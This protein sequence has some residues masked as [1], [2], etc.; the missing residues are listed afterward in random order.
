MY[1]FFLLF[2]FFFFFNDTATTE[3]YTLSL[4]DALPIFPRIARAY[5]EPFGNSSALPTYFCAKLAKEDGQD[6]LLA[7]D[8]G[9]ELFGGNERYAK[10]LLFASYEQ[11]PS[12]IRHRF[13][14][15]ILSIP[16][17]RRLPVF[18]KAYSYVTQAKT[19]LPDRLEAYNFLHRH[20]AS[21]VFSDELVTS[22]N[23]DQPLELLRTL[24]D[25]PHDASP[26]NR[27]LFLD[28]ERTLHDNDL[29]KVN[30]MCQ[31]AGIDVA[32]PMLDD[33]VIEFSC[34]IPS[35]LKLHNN[36]LRWFYK[37][38]CIGFLPESILNKPKHGFGLPFGIWAATHPQLQ[39]LAYE[40][41][42]A[43]RKRHLFRSDFLE[44]TIEMHRG[45]HAAYYGELIWV[46][47]M[48]EQWLQAHV[49]V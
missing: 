3:I 24:Y 27:M 44:K 22:V 26:L 34:Q 43:L 9:D 12:S 6:L 39:S 2:S 30:R 25:T 33:D 15:P 14:E 18:R 49:D 29:V 13:I 1:M 23:I 48:L 35:R 5:D 11:L 16:G 41:V 45:E 21:G 10:Q 31:L 28:W 38:A 4:H 20:P 47:M 8:G 32:Y 7:G 17:L 36:R 19:P 42:L 46:L 40:S 37:Q